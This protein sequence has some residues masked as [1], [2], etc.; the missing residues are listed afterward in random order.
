LFFSS[1][2]SF[3]FFVCSLRAAE[4][5]AQKAK[6]IL[7]KTRTELSAA[8]SMVDKVQRKYEDLENK[9][10]TLLQTVVTCNEKKSGA[11]SDTETCPIR[12]AQLNAQTVIIPLTIHSPPNPNVMT[13]LRH[14]DQ[15][16]KPIKDTFVRHCRTLLTTGASAAQRR[17]LSL[18]EGVC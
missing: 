18:R 1:K 17:A 7:Q 13:P 14:V 16:G 9:L 5:K 11:E 12:Q 15:R 8:L 6:L 2:I 4:N 10:H 3:A